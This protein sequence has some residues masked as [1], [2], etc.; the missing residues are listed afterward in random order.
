MPRT[1]C[2]LLISCP[3]VCFFPSLEGAQLS[4]LKIASFESFFPVL[5]SMNPLN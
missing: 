3:W 1:Y 4:H 2:P 5:D